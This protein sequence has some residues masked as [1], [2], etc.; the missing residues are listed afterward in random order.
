MEQAEGRSDILCVARSKGRMC[1]GNDT[2]R[3]GRRQQSKKGR[4]SLTVFFS[5][6]IL[7]SS[8]THTSEKAP[9]GL[10]SLTHTLRVWDILII[11]VLQL[12]TQGSMEFEGTMI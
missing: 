5:V 10:R 4:K 2:K 6:F 3:L 9:L 8:S 1:S 12:G 11:V 7:V